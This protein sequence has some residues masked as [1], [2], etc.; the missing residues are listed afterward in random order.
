MDIETDVLICGAGPTG[1][2]AALCL[3][4]QGVQ[5][6]IID[7]KIE[8]DHTSKALL[9][10]PRTIE[11]LDTLG[12]VD[13]L[14]AW[15]SR[16]KGI[17]L[18]DYHNT[19]SSFDFSHCDTS[20]PF[21]LSVSQHVVENVLG[22]ELKKNG[23]KILRSHEFA[24]FSQDDEHVYSII[25]YQNEQ[26]TIKSKYLLGCDGNQ[27]DFSS[28]LKIPSTSQLLEQHILMAE[29]PL[30]KSIDGNY[31][32]GFFS[33]QGSLACVPSESTA[34]LIVEQTSDAKLINIAQPELKH[35]QYAV[36][37]RV[38]NPFKLEGIKW[39]SR[40]KIDYGYVKQLSF[41][42]VFLLGDSAYKHAN[43]VGQGMNTG[44]QDAYHLAWQ[45]EWVLNKNAATGFLRRYQKER[46]PI[47]QQVI[48]RTA[49]LTKMLSLHGKIAYQ[50]QK[51]LLD[52]LWTFPSLKQRLMTGVAQFKAY[53]IC[54]AISLSGF[55]KPYQIGQY[56]PT[57]IQ[58]GEN[59]RFNVK[60]YVKSNKITCL[61]NISDLRL[62]YW[63]TFLDGLK[64]YS[65]FIQVVA[66]VAHYDQKIEVPPF[67]TVLTLKNRPIL[68]QALQLGANEYILIRPDYCAIGYGNINKPHR[69]FTWLEKIITY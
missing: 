40:I 1:L 24:S 20:F 66:I 53:H 11:I 65:D 59:R 46:Q 21:M 47:T 29:V 5:C 42:R 48:K 45:L 61:V 60:P 16:L 31:L 62:Q 25:K 18:I 50:V 23:L 49:D 6:V 13:E 26:I 7:Q 4:R 55:R 43:V 35:F 38:R 39:S 58:V 8:V 69:L 63:Q 3:V 33:P 68:L 2:V 19:Q 15:G 44:M 34:R 64:S 56:V 27:G 32:Y 22:L 54:K 37:K 28:H 51:S 52:M 9:I 17:R 41:K 36:I 67:V 30:P 14:I 57:R 10:T 12:L